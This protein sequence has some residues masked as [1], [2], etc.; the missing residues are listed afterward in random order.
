MEVTLTSTQDQSRNTTK[1]W[2]N[3]PDQM[4][5][6]ERGRILKTLYTRKNLLQ[7]NL[8]TPAQQNTRCGGHRD[9]QLTIWREGPTKEGPN[10][11]QN[12]K[13]YREPT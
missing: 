3:Y 5:E 11:N 2:R 7:H 10:K 12:I 6:Q 13:T 8:S 1:W 4:T 9:P